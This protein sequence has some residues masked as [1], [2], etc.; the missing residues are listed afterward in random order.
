ML[1]KR[2][3]IPALWALATLIFTITATAKK[4]SKVHKPDEEI[5]GQGNALL[6]RNP[7][8]IRSRNLFFGPGGEEHAPHSTY[9]FEKEDL[10]GT[11][12]KFD[13]RD[14]NGIK[15]RVKMGPEARPETAASRLVW[16]VGYSANED[17][18]LPE[19]QVQ[20][21]PEPLRRGQN[22]VHPKGTLHNVRL[23]RYL[24]GEKK[25][26]VW[27]WKD[28]PFTNTRQL[29]GFRVVMALINNWDLKDDNNAIYDEKRT[30]G[31][32]SAEQIYM[33]S[34]LGASFGTTGI[35]WSH[36]K[37]KDNLKAYTH[38]KFVSKVTPD[39]VDFNVP[40]RPALINIFD[41][42]EF[43][44]RLQ[45]RWI[46]KDIP[47]D[48]ARWIGQLLAQ[49]SPNQVRDAFRAAGYT[50]EEVEGFTKVVENRISELSTL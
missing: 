26:D 38:S 20:D 8:D 50:P 49:L 22:F 29:N 4:G 44:S 36:A 43:I 18:F 27:R 2:Q 11:S 41:L 15:W 32:A 7:V 14:K 9:T 46:G 37:S 25:V 17:Y 34:D 28:N 30:E 19:L 35:G 23:K 10:K 40:S 39:F 5:T 3:R 42:P 6:W 1:K 21:M 24:R 13:V 16:A 48:D 47:R 45:L 12:P 33:V 31:L